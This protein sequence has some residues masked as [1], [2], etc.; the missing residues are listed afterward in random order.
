MLTAHQNIEITHRLTSTT[1]RPSRR[2]LLDSIRAGPFSG[3]MVDEFLRC[4]IRHAQKEA[5]ADFAIILNAFQDF[6]L[7]FSTHAWQRLYLAFERQL[8]HAGYVAHL[9]RVPD[10]RNR[11]RTQPGYLQQLQ[12]SG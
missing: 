10:Q 6:L 11:L 5:S 7:A 1:Q 12:H 8:L 4:L 3:K 2:Y 9:I